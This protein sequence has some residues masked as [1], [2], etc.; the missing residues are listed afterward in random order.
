MH[1]QLTSEIDIG[2]TPEIIWQILTDLSAYHEWNPF[3]VS[4]QG[5]AEAGCRLTLRMQ[6][7]VGRAVTLTPTVADVVDGHRLSWRGRFLVRG[8]CDA[9]HVFTLEA[10]PGGT[11]RLT[12]TEQFS[13]ALVPLLA[14]S[15]D[16]GTLPAFHAMNTALRQ[17]AENAAVPERG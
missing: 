15:L 11:T 17:R 8:L 6:P 16:R 14:R 12:Q 13:G 9:E 3:V 7:A 1:K 5:R 2:A 4:A 10:R